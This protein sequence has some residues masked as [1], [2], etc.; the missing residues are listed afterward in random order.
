MSIIFPFGFM[1]G[2]EY[3]Q[4]TPFC[5]RYPL[6]PVISFLLHQSL[7]SHCLKNQGKGCVCWKG[8]QEAIGSSRERLC[9]AQDDTAGPARNWVSDCL[10]A[11]L[12]VLS[13]WVPAFYGIRGEGIAFTKILQLCFKC[14]VYG[15]I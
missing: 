8:C 9:I 3:S 13:H 12:S 7:G 1:P 4:A 6:H 10:P 2:P 5:L 11:P 14:S 15:P